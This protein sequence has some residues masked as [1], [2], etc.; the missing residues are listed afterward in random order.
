MA[1]A[2]NIASKQKQ[3][4]IS[5]FFEK[6]KHFLGFDTL[7]RSLITAVKEAVDNSL[8]ACEEARI[9]PEINV[10]IRKLKGD[11]IGLICEDNGPGIPKD[12]VPNVFGR[13]LLGSRFHA[14]RQT[15]GQQGIGITGVVMYSQLTTGSKTKVTSKIEKDDYASVTEIALDTRRNKAIPTTH[16]RAE[17]LNYEGETVKHGLKIETTMKAKYQRGKQSVFQYLRMTSIVNP[18][19]TIRLI[20][21][22]DEGTIDEGHWISTTEKL[23]KTVKEIKPHPYSVTLAQLQRMLKETDE[24]R[25]SGFLQHEFNPMPGR[26]MKEITEISRVER[27]RVPSRIKTDDAAS[28]LAAFSEVKYP[29]PKNFEVCLSPIEDLLIK[30]GLSKAI[31]SRFASTVSRNPILIQ[32]VPYQVE[33]GL[34]F[35]GDLPSD[36][37]IE[38]LRFANRVPLMYQ[39]GGCLLTKGLES[40]DWKN[41]GLDHP[42]A[43]GLPKGPAAVLIHLASTN[44]QFTSEAKEAVADNDALMKEIRKSM[45]EV[46]RGLK[47]HLKTRKE[48]K[49][50]RE[51]FDL[52]NIILPEISRKSSQM[53]GRDEPPLAPVITKIMNAVFIEDEIVWNNERKENI[54]TITMYNYTNRAR[55]YRIFAKWPEREGV[56][57]VEDILRST[58]ETNGLRKWVLEALDPGEKVEIIFVVS[59]LEK[60]DWNETDIFFKGEKDIIGANRIDEKLLDEMKEIENTKK[61]TEKLELAK[62]EHKSNI[63]ENIDSGLSRVR[64]RSIVGDNELESEEFLSDEEK[65]I[66]IP[67]DRGNIS[68]WVAKGEEK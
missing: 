24:N 45:Q 60:G 37:P 54:C 62:K 16:D 9:L 19:A 12:A 55:K 27:G 4:S 25:L 57:I 53:L 64:D 2:E 51:K 8:D 63:S 20:V 56:E 3:I 49:K 10:D 61:K 26:A 31:D 68:A 40:V 29:E 67:V 38:V 21:R 13:F 7:Q 48:R 11:R 50:A 33:V 58:R 41:Y 14:I 18:H 6:N 34:V 44:V 52:I 32:G 65:E 39:Q 5:E 59:G 66:Q 22:D 35:G 15:R 17:L 28:I 1:D 47:A 42:G 36:G 30:K 23:P 43:K 46:G